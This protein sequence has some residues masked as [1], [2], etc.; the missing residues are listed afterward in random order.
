MI[1]AVLLGKGD[2]FLL[3]SLCRCQL[4]LLLPFTVLSETRE[5]SWETLHAKYLSHPRSTADWIE[6]GKEFEKEWLFP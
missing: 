2:I 4:L 6:L 3:F 1:K 5:V